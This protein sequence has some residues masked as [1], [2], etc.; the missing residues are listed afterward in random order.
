MGNK[1]ISDWY[2]GNHAARYESMRTKNPLWQKENEAVASLVQRGPV[3]DVPI[4]TGRYIPIYQ[5]KGLAFTGM[6]ISPDMIAEASK[7]AKFPYKISSITSIPFDN[8]QFGTVV[9]TRMMNW[10]DCADMQKAV[11]ELRRVADESIVG[12]RFG[13]GPRRMF[14]HSRSEFL[15][16]LGGDWITDEVL[17][18]D[19]DYWLFKFR[20]PCWKDVNEQFQWQPKPAQLI[21][22]NWSERLG[23]NKVSL[24]S[25]PVR[26]EYMTGQQ[27]WQCV[28]SLSDISPI[29]KNIKGK[30]KK[31]SGPITMVR[32]AGMNVVIDGR[33]RAKKWRNDERRHA[34]FVVG[35]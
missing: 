3:L 1:P 4:G 9:C 32:I 10:L 26:C 14:D 11:S 2:Y 12:V 29:M 17:L 6:D 7:R 34:V 33:N 13:K 30:P 5:E 27:I 16:A 20:R 31:E 25:L 23:A 18:G 15:D 19:K 21:A 8:H 28:D 35:E 22:D 24:E